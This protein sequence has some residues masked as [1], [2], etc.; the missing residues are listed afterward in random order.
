MALAVGFIF[1][2]GNKTRMMINCVIIVLAEIHMLK[3]MNVFRWENGV[4]D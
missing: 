3:S 2:E 4:V 1:H